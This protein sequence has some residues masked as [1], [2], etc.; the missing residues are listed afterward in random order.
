MYDKTSV[1]LY[2]KLLESG[3]EKKRHSIGHCW[4]KGS[5][6]TS[7]LKRLFR[8]EISMIKEVTITN[9]IKIHRMRCNA[10]SNDGVWK[11]LRSKNKYSELDARLLNPY[12][13]T[14]RSQA[15]EGIE[16]AAVQKTIQ[17]ITTPTKFTESMEYEV[18]SQQPTVIP[19]SQCK[20]PVSAESHCQPPGTSESQCKPHVATESQSKHTVAT[21]SPCKPPVATESQCKPPV[22]TESQ[23][24]HPV[25]TESQC[26]PPVATE[27]Q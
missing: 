10:N 26:K 8:E 11:R 5:G 16:A 21:E 13:E 3:S 15:K 9:G 25:A 24:K 19:E 4:E 7:L 18:A 2:L 20:P 27:C 23:C 6:K 22:A 1:P 14:L 17:D 12:E